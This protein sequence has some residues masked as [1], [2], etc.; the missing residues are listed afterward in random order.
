MLGLGLSGRRIRFDPEYVEAHRDRLWLAGS[1]DK[2]ER[3]RRQSSA[4]RSRVADGTLDLKDSYESDWIGFDGM[5]DVIKVTS[6]GAPVI[7][8][9]GKIVRTETTALGLLYKGQEGFDPDSKK[10]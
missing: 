3:P 8:I 10:K 1:S 6:D 2:P 7:G 9:V 4:I 5:G